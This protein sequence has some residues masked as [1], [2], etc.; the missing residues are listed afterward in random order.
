MYCTGKADKSK[1]AAAPFGYTVVAATVG[2]P[3]VL[4]K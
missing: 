4:V 3:Q 1:G 2:V